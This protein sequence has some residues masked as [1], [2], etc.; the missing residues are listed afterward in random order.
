[1]NRFVDKIMREVIE[2]EREPSEGRR[3]LLRIARE[4]Q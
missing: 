3:Q 1:M 2:L 4:E